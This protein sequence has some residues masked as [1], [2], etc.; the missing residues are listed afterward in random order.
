VLAGLGIASERIDGADYLFGKEFVR[1]CKFGGVAKYNGKG[2]KSLLS[3]KPNA[4][5]W[6]CTVHSV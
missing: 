2:W 5:E 6:V 3:Y 4:I 1:L